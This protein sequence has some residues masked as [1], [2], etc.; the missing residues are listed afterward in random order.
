M[1]KNNLTSLVIAALDELGRL[2]ALLELVELAIDQLETRDKFQIRLELLLSSYLANASNHMDE[3]E[4]HLENARKLITPPAL[5]S[6]NNISTHP[7]TGK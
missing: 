6:D 2:E 3:L 5:D 7:T 4:T 1:P